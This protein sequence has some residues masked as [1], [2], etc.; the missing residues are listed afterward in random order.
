MPKEYISAKSTVKGKPDRCYSVFVDS[1]GVYSPQQNEFNDKEQPTTI[2]KWFKGIAVVK[3]KGEGD[4]ETRIAHW[5]VQAQFK[6][7]TKTNEVPMT[8]S[9]RQGES[10]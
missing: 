9:V 7:N 2:N 6:F 8:S 1:V 3:P 10:R 4:I 5:S